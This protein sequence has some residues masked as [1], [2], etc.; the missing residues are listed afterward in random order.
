[1]GSHNLSSA[2]AE[3]LEAFR[4]ANTSPVTDDLYAEVGE[5]WGPDFGAFDA[6]MHLAHSEVAQV[7]SVDDAI[8]FGELLVELGKRLDMLEAAF[9]E[10]EGREID[11]NSRTALTVFVKHNRLQ[12]PLMGAES[13]G[14]IVA[15]WMN[16]RTSISVRFKDRYRLDYA[17][18]NSKD[19]T[20][21]RVWGES[22][23][24]RFRADHPVIK[25]FE[26]A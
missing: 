16:P 7:A 24:A 22:D 25:Q 15:T 21:S 6:V 8:G 14:V 2:V 20:P 17:I 10:D 11:G 18:T 9:T 1:M 4:R 5:V 12:I 26:F 13:S 23:L 19:T 3:D